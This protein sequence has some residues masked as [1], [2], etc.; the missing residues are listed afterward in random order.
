M[1]R[2]WQLSLAAGLAVLM[3]LTIGGCGSSASESKTVKIATKPMTEQ[4][5]LGEMM[6]ELIETKT[7]LTVE[8]A[9]GVGGGTSNIHPAMLKGDFD[10]YPEY[11]G[12]AWYTVLKKTDSPDEGTL[13]Q[14]LRKDYEDQFNLTWVGLY[15]FNNT[16]SL[17]MKKSVAEQYG[18]TTY[19]QL[20]ATSP[21]LVFGANPDFYEREDGFNGLTSTYALKF[22][23]TKEMDIGLTYQALKGGEVDVIT[24][25]TTDGQLDDP[26]LVVLKDDKGYFKNYY[27]GTVARQDTLK[28]YN[29]LEGVLKLLDDQ[30]SEADMIK[31][32]HRVEIDKQEDAVVAHDFLVEKRLVN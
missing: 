16:Y 17:A 27:C 19:S 18:I 30:I 15:G 20:V 29:E 13:Y 1:K 9:K 14:Q 11:T 5:V 31:M 28:K 2:K 12:T 8:I 6:K 25:F 4:L 26:D 3:M 21:N 7:D 24:V 23:E 22:K 10:L 32:N